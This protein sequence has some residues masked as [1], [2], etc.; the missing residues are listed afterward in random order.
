MKTTKFLERMTPEEFQV[1]VENGSLRNTF[2]LDTSNCSRYDV[3]RKQGKSDL[4]AQMEYFSSYVTV[5]VP[6]T[7]INVIKGATIDHPEWGRMKVDREYCPGIWE[8]SRVGKA[9][10]CRILNADEF[11]FW[12]L[13]K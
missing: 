3:M 4:E 12:Y 10:D 1:A 11:H 2:G 13:L 7:A 6:L 9:S 8:I 5:Y